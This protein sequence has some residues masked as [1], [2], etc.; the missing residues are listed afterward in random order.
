M[1]AAGRALRRWSPSAR[2]ATPS[3]SRARR[4]SH[5]SS[6][7]SLRRP[8]TSTA[9]GARHRTA[10]RRRCARQGQ[11]RS[12]RRARAPRPTTRRCRR[13]SATTSRCCG[14]PRPPAWLVP[15]VPAVPRPGSRV[16]ALTRIPD[17]EVRQRH[18]KRHHDRWGLRLRPEP[19]RE[20][21]KDVT[22]HYSSAPATSSSDSAKSDMITRVRQKH[23]AGRALYCGVQEWSHAGFVTCA[24]VERCRQ[25]SRSVR[26]LL[27]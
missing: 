21:Q 14:P 26:I 22:A 18:D 10:R 15:R 3:G 13:Y 6:V 9:P 11:R 25:S 27:I 8:G 23:G 20:A 5:P 19:F 16:D 12:V 7:G 2:S 1:A 4:A 17:A 24:D